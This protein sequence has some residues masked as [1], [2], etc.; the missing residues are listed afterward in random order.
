MLT[1]SV[2]DD[3]PFLDV[4]MDQHVAFKYL[5]KKIVHNLLW[6]EPEAY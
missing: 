5:K 4:A 2:Y 1:S 6:L 3:W